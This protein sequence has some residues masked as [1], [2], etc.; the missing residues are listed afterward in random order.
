MTR[1]ALRLAT[2]Q[3]SRVALLADSPSCCMARCV[4]ALLTQELSWSACLY[5]TVSAGAI[6]PQ[7]LPSGAP[8]QS[9]ISLDA[10]IVLLGCTQ[11]LT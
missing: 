11:I 5:R 6:T 4:C 2:G 7:R 8:L 10:V 9:W 3:L 1:L